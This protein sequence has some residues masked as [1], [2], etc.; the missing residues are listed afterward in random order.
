[1]TQPRNS[2][3]LLLLWL[4][5]VSANAGDGAKSSDPDVDFFERRIRPV[6]VE[7]CYSCHS[8]QHNSSKGGLRVD[9]RSAILAG[10]E[11]GAAVDL[12]DAE[13][14]ILIAALRYETVQ[15]P[16]SGKLPDDVIADFTAWIER[17]AAWP[18]ESELTAP[19]QTSEPF[20]L[21]RRRDAHWAWQPLTSPVPPAVEANG[22]AITDIDRFIWAGLE[23]AGLQPAAS[24]DRATLLRRLSFD[25]IGL[26][27][28][29]AELE[30]YVH[31]S[32]DNAT[33]RVVDRLLDSSRFG[34]RW[35]RHWLD[36]VRYAESRGHEFDYDIPGAYQYRDYVI[37]AL[38]AD[39]PYNEF[40]KEHLAGDQLLHPRVHPQQQF[41]ESILGT[42]FWFLGEW[43]HSPVDIRRDEVDRLDNMIDCFS[44]AFLGL[45]VSCA[46]CHDHKFDA[47]SSEDYYALSGVLQSSQFRT[48]RFEASHRD[49]LVAEQLSQIDSAY[50]ELLDAALRRIVASARQAA[51]APWLSTVSPVSPANPSRSFRTL[52]DFTQPRA[53][54]AQQL[55][56]DGFAYADRPVAAGDWVIES[57]TKGS[58]VTL[59]AIGAV[60]NDPFWNSLRTLPDTTTVLLNETIPEPAGRSVRTSSFEVKNG[61]VS[62]LVRGTGTVFA[63]V[64]S[65]RLVTGPLHG[66]T[67]LRA[68]DRDGTDARWYPLYLSK[69]RD[70]RL[71]LEITPEPGATFEVLC[72]VDGDT[73]WNPSTEAA[74]QIYL[75]T[76]SWLQ[77]LVSQADP[78]LSVPLT[79]L[80]RQWIAERESL[81]SH[82]K[83]ESRLAMVMVD[84]SGCD[85]RVLIRGNPKTPG[86]IVPRR[87]LAAID[88]LPLGDAQSSGRLELAEQVTDPSNPL[89]ARVIVNRVWH[90]LL[91]RGIVSTVDD[92]GVMGEPPTHPELL[93]H[94]A[95]WFLEHDQSI[96]R[97]IRYI[98]L[99][100]T[101]QMSG[102]YSE[103]ANRIDPNNRL[104]HHRAPKRLEAEAIRD[105]MLQVSGN[106][107]TTMYGEPIPIGLNQFLEGRGRPPRSGPVDGHG[108]RSIYLSVR[109]N[110]LSP[111]MTAFDTPVPFSTVGCRTVSNVPAQAL[112]LMN[113]PFVHH[114]ARLFA[115]RLVSSEPSDSRARIHS[116]FLIAYARPP[117]PQELDLIINSLPPEKRHRTSDEIEVQTWAR[118]VMAVFNSKEFIFIP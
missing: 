110:F 58:R 7:K 82:W 39:L 5:T 112:M 11:M 49:A 76:Q 22:Q 102:S 116:L 37:R 44:K 12:D 45:T 56:P 94:L 33:Q 61:I 99:S 9:S 100:K 84:G 106:L 60:R 95:N 113:D 108:R 90:H 8:S 97:L 78:S 68:D 64:D 111:W 87:F 27:P 101:Y 75:D 93:D 86:P 92:F 79:N 98:V 91:S 66:E 30:A 35:G 36:L 53:E 103:L 117:S 109:R 107:D 52:F 41:N 59:Q 3:W 6:L 24:V 42:G 118:I 71:H 67:I 1:M 50:R 20:D 18:A 31:D 62:L 70:H 80:Q 65:H 96:K 13:N 17:G 104:Y 77:D 48:Y 73:P 16:P 88:P 69:Y 2:V 74:N 115:Q 54:L 28:T 29:P 15:M 57:S 40:V 38:N 26:P 23:S 43:A 21:D 55:Y 114:Q 4:W 85:A 34:E 32:S 10:G 89:Y 81:Q 63:C 72:A 47:I 51:P 19:L 105:A 25:I 46:R 14:S 83:S